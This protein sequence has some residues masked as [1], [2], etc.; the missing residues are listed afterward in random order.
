MQQPRRKPSVSRCMSWRLTTE[1][2][3]RSQ[4]IRV[5]SMFVGSW[6]ERDGPPVSPPERRGFGSMVIASMAMSAVEG[7]VR[8]RS[9]GSG[10]AFE[11]PGN[12]WTGGGGRWA[13]LAGY[14]RPP[15][16]QSSLST[17]RVTLEP[18][19]GLP[20]RPGRHH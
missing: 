7:E 17:R 6:T 20:V 11:L 13:Y 4:R 15:G 8:L 14:S 16:Y 12:E 2:T 10:V 19:G 3:G 9:L 18:V 5:T 1:N